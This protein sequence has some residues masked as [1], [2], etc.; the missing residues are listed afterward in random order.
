[1]SPG[2]ACAR[3]TGSF[4][5]VRETGRAVGAGL[6]EVVDDDLGAVRLERLFDELD[7]EGMHLIVILGLLV[8]EHEVQ[9]DLVGLIN[10]RSMASD[11][12]AHVIAQHPGDGLEI[13][14][15][16]SQEVGD[17]VGFVRMG[18]KND[19]VR[20]HGYDGLIVRGGECGCPNAGARMKW[21]SEGKCGL[22]ERS[23]GLISLK[24]SVTSPPMSFYAAL[25]AWIA[26]AVLLTIGVVM[27]TK[28]AFAV[29]IIGT[30]GFVFAFIKWG[31]L[32]H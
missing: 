21:L 28:G 26:I 5:R 1:M 24:S 8:G 16:A 23:G 14:F 29:L 2:V 18:P 25:F 15:A 6:L 10:D 9:R 20:E 19:N 11:H 31:C 17:C 30:L 7:M 3:F 4:I 22:I 32:T 27:A 13:L 12:L